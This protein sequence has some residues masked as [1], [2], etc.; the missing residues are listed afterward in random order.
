MKLEE[1]RRTEAVARSAKPN[2]TGDQ[3]SSIVLRSVEDIALLV[4]S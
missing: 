1:R 3:I 4:R 2:R